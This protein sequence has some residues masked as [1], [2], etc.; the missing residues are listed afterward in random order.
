M[1]ALANEPLWQDKDKSKL[2]KKMK[3]LIQNKELTMGVV[4]GS[5][6]IVSMVVLCLTMSLS[7]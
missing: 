1:Q 3:D 6:G 4:S 5:K 7:T 2:N